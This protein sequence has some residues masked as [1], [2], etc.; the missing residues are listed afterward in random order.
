[1][2]HIY[3]LAVDPSLN[4]TGYCIAK[5]TQQRNGY[6]IEIVELANIPNHHFDSKEFGRKLRHIE[7][8]L[9]QLRNTYQPSVVVKENLATANHSQLER[10]APVHALIHMVFENSAEIVGYSPTRIK[11]CVTGDGDADK[12]DVASALQQYIDNKVIQSQLNLSC[13]ST[14]DQSDS[15]GILWTY[16]ID[17]GYIDNK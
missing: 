8:R 17:K 16:L 11:K 14:D 6:R 7:H 15:L 13:F 9:I 1:M 2:N 5:I 12:V 4:N 10:L 3:V